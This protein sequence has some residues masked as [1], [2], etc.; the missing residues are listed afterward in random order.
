MGGDWILMAQ[1]KYWNGTAW[2]NAVVGAQ[3][4]AGPQGDPATASDSFKTISVTGQDNVVADSSTDTL[5]FVAGSNVNITTNATSDSITI[6]ATD[7]DTVTNAFTNIE[8][9]GQD[10]VSAESTSDTLTLVAGDN[11]IITTN[12]TNDTIT[13]SSSGGS[14][15]GASVTVSDTAPAEPA[16]GDLWYNSLV[17]K[18]Y[19]YYDG[20]WVEAN[21]AQIGPE[22][23]FNVSSTAPEGPAEGQVW[24]NSDNAR[25]Y[26]F[27]DN[28]W[29]EASSNEPGPEG[30][31]KVSET[32]PEYPQE[33]D[34]WFKS[35]TGRFYIY[36]D[37]YWVENTSSL[38]GPSGVVSV[39]SP[40]TNT[41]TD[42][43]A[44]IGIDQSLLSVSQN[45]VVDLSSD[46]STINSTLSGKQNTITGAATSIVSS[47]LTSSRVLVSDGSGK[48][49][50]S[51]T[52]STEVGYLSGTSSSVQN[53]LNTKASTG[54]AIAM[55][56]VF[57]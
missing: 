18:T 17:G 1:L 8:V 20:F 52:T 30:K 21:P 6:A 3:G 2:V 47:N 4:P 39:T 51:G 45:Q 25:F 54:K 11:V 46:L 38:T 37:G 16:E 36:Y 15:G 56:I 43:E 23:K 26:V 24:Y 7:T 49:A 40:I 13:I 57:G 28:F 42:N 12:A 48:V 31:F 55:A 35:T 5:T 9:S 14:S 27:Y 29:I 33:G 34:A 44:V 50:I 41:G 10:T 32:A 19:I 22:G 53:Q